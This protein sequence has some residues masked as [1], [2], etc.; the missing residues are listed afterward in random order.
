MKHLFMLTLAGTLLAGMVLPAVAA[1]VAE[2][3][4]AITQEGEA[5]VLL[6]DMPQRTRGANMLKG[7]LAL[8][9]SAGERITGQ[10]D[11]SRTM[12]EGDGLDFSKQLVKGDN[13]LCLDIGEL[14]FTFNI[15]FNVGDVSNIEGAGGV[16]PVQG[17][18][19]H[20]P[21]PPQGMREMHSAEMMEM[22]RQHHP[23]LRPE[24][25]E[26][27]MQIPPDIDPGF[28]EFIMHI[29]KLAWEYPEFRERLEMM[30]DR[31]QEHLKR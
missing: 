13:S 9:K 30:A 2:P 19:V 22:M 10:N 20:P 12:I 14:D 25:M 31:M 29:G 26:M 6:V 11:L 16:P 5:E 24:V 27:L 7:L 8:L 15:N 23:E 4:L 1:E 17:P 18:E 21:G 3:V 28:L